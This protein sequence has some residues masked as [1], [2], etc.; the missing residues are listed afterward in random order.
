MK[1]K[2]DGNALLSPLSGE[3]PAGKDLRYTATYDEIK[4]AR[5]E[6]EA[7]GVGDEG[8]ERKR[9]DWNRVV[10]L[11]SDAL[12]NKTKDLQIAAWLTEALIKIDGFEGLYMGLQILN[13]LL[14]NFWEQVYP[15]LEDNDLEFRIG[16]IEFMNEKLPFSIRQ[17]PI[18]DPKRTPGY[19]LLKFEESRQVGYESD[20][21]TKH[22]EVSEEKKNVRAEAVSEGKITAEDFDAAVNKSPSVFYETLA[23][24]VNLCRTEFA[25][26]SQL[27]DEKFGSNTP[28]LGELQE[29]LEAHGR[30]KFLA[31]YLKK[32]EK[33]EAGVTAE[34]E[35]ETETTEETGAGNEGEEKAAS[36]EFAMIQPLPGQQFSGFESLEKAM[37]QD[38]LKKLKG[39]GIREALDQLYKTASRMP[40]LREKSRY[41]LLMAKLCLKADRPD[42]A[43]P[44]VEELYALIEELHLGRWESPMWIAEVN[45]AL[46]QCLSAGMPSDEDRQRAAELF[47]KLCAIDVT[48]AMS[49]KQS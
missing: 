39:G 31:K 27:V 46:Y 49:Y 4:E 11:C 47:K 22:G 25:T 18:T 14:R 9:A 32:E 1:S 7:F 36:A 42:L 48:K 3:N 21:I 16:P 15:A 19:S 17:I 44:I 26:F 29:A 34:Q 37:W 45:E 43:R 5:R 41:K 23:G 6:K 13:G 28:R 8:P 20:L 38:S 35:R 40:S 10:A 12:L 33:T 24:H 2:I 30:L